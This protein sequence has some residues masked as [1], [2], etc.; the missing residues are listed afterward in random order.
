MIT[1]RF[2][3][4]KIRRRRCHSA[5]AV[6]PA[7]LRTGTPAVPGQGFAA[8]EVD[9][10]ITSGRNF[11][12]GKTGVVIDSPDGPNV[13]LLLQLRTWRLPGRE[14]QI[15]AMNPDIPLIER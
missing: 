2:V 6:V 8:S 10:A 11:R 4:H 13:L 14:G 1:R 12:V 15:Y 9:A 5:A 7:A 3:H